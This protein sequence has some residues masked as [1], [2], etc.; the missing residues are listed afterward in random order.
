MEPENIYQ[1]NC[2]IVT[3]IGINH[4]GDLSMAKTLIDEA[5]DAGADIV[6]FQLYVPEKLWPDHLLMCRGK[7]WYSLVERTEL[8]FNQAAEIANYCSARGIE[9]MASAFDTERIAWLEKLG[10][11]HIKIGNRYKD[12]G[13]IEAAGKTGKEVWMSHTPGE[14]FDVPG[15][16]FNNFRRIYCISQ[17]PTALTD[18]HLGQ[19]PFGNGYHEYYGFSDHSLGIEASQVAIS[20]GAQMVE[21]H[22]TFDRNDKRG[23][24]HL[25]SI[26][27]TQLKELVKFRDH[28]EAAL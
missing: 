15:S 2:L 3:E 22:F 5:A 16:S 19:I 21:K 25:C 14:P 20:R 10:V 24:D 1:H 26:E 27:H 12:Y 18:L 4:N 9:F 17:Y 13:V 6:K 23:P 28:V 11:T 8:T 7:N